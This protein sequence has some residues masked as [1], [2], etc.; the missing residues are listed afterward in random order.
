MKMMKFIQMFMLLMVSAAC[1]SCAKDDYRIPVGSDTVVQVPSKVE[2]RQEDGQWRLYCNGEQMYINGAACN[3]F[4]TDVAKFGGNVFRIYSCTGDD[5]KEI[6]DEAYKNGLYVNVGIYIRRERDGFDYNDEAAVRSQFE[7]VQA[8]VKKFMNHPAVLMWSIGNEAESNY[9]NRK[10]WTAINDIARMIH[11]TDPNHPTTTVLASANEDH[12]KNILELAPEIDILSLNTYAPNL[13]DVYGKIT[14]A[15]WT[16]PYMITEFGPRGTWQMNPEPERIL[17]WGALVEQTSTEK[18]AD[19]L[20]AWQESIKPNEKNGCIGSFV[21]VWGYQ[22]HG[23]VLNW[24]GLFNK[25]RY[26]YGAVDAMQYCWTGEY[27]SVRAPRIETRKDMTM[28]G[29]VAEDK[30]TVSPS[31]DNTAKVTATSPSGATLKYHWLIYKEGDA[32]EDGSMPDGIEGLISDPSRSEITFKA[33]SGAGGYRLYV[34]VLDDVNRKVASA[35]I[36]FLVQ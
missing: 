32:A 17:P 10:L 18:E 8:C 16:G 35:V 3:N 20:K 30:I 33:P 26:S 36:P 19:Y 22:S 31:S 4:Y 15:G 23:E 5:T 34:F 7:E 2:V 6:L 12:I 13:P 9:T 1:S 25:D 27:P 14:S 28:N 24:Y 11:E 29:M 21:F